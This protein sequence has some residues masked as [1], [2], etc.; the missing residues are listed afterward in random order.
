MVDTELKDLKLKYL[1][2]ESQYEK[3]ERAKDLCNYYWKNSL[4]EEALNIGLEGLKFAEDI[5]NKAL[6]FE[7]NTSIGISQHVQ[8]HYVIAREYFEKADKIADE[9]Q[10]PHLKIRSYINLGNVAYHLY[11]RIEG[12]SY[13][14]KGVKLSENTKINQYIPRLYNNIANCYSELNQND[15][16]LE[17]YKKSLKITKEASNYANL[18]FN[19]GN[20]YL[21]E[22][23]YALAL[24][25]FKKARDL[26]KNLN[27]Y[28]YYVH[29]INYIGKV[30]VIKQDYDKALTIYKE[31]LKISEQFNL[32]HYKESVLLSLADIYTIMNDFK[33]AKEY[34][35]YFLNNK[36]I[37]NKR[38]LSNF[39]KSYINYNKKLGDIS[40]AFRFMERL[41]SLNDELFNEEIAKQAT[42]M[43]AKFDYEHNKK[44]LE[45]SR[46]RN[47]ELVSYQK[48]IENQKNELISLSKSK[49][50]ILGMIS[51]DLKNYIGSISSILEIASIKDQC[52][53]ENKYVG[54]ISNIC[55]K[56][57]TLV[58]DILLLN[59]I[60]T[61]DYILDLEKYDINLDLQHIKE[62]L[63]LLAN[64]KD[65]EVIFNF[66]NT[67]LICMIQIDS[68]HRII[69]NLFM[70]ALKFTN[71]KGS[72]SINITKTFLQNK[73]WAEIRIIDSGIGIPNEH[74]PYIFDKHTSYG[75]KGTQGEESTGLG[76]FIVK[77][78]IDLH[79][80]NIEV[81]SVEGQGSEFIVY[82]P[83]IIED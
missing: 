46:L 80:G 35:T 64:K 12:L 63:M 52:F 60:E 56:S 41:L 54:L 68:F 42:L 15:R 24:G 72:I 50:N 36:N 82:L 83:L 18:H 75:R 14:F 55:D 48:V 58:K 43:N 45:I 34:Y 77:R 19:I 38:T 44:E 79:Q 11:D 20:L 8:G 29:S 5:Q 32:L 1:H 69:D 22:N 7:L 78:L 57:V 27:Q 28:H 67:P 21:S 62:N 61:D 51:H 33:Q 30:Y 6:M 70:N 13:Y 31:S 71:P 47:I 4:Y 23:D 37:E 25:Y 26:F 3:A 16:A 73:A 53:K 2:S 17:Y 40:T 59:R 65:I 74:I 9:L 39:Y 81:N 10:L 49:D 76:L 66:S